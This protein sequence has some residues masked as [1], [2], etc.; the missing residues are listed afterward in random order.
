MAKPSPGA[1]ADKVALYEKLVATIPRVQR[2]GAGFPYTSVNG[3]MFSI[4]R[5]DGVV[6]L[7]LPDAEREAFVAKYKTGP[8]EMYGAAMNEY[9]AVPDPLLV[10]TQQLEPYFAASCAYAESLAPK[11]TGR[12]KASS[13]TSEPCSMPIEVASSAAGG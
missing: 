3:N 8:V 12:A 6:C 4:L 10:T 9:V 13:A 5:K 1:P 11:P 7:R 2:K